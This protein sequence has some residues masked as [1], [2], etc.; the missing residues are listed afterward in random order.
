MITT[1]NNFP[2]PSKLNPDLAGHV[3]LKATNALFD[4]VAKEER[5]IRANPLARTTDLLKRSLAGFYK[6]RLLID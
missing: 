5:E 6:N 2:R 3:C 1:Y 4:M